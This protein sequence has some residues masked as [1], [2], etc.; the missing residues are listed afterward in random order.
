MYNLNTHLYEEN[1]F[2]CSRLELRPKVNISGS[3]AESRGKT[4]PELDNTEDLL[5]GVTAKHDQ[6]KGQKGVGLKGGTW[7]RGISMAGDGAREGRG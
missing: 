6:G 4:S 1:V 5:S 7:E 2:C 3:S